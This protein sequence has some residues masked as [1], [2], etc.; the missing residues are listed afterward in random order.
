MSVATTSHSDVADLS[1]AYRRRDNEL[2]T[3]N[4][5]SRDLSATR[6]DESEIL[7]LVYRYAS[8][9]AETSTFAISLIDERTREVDLALWFRD[10]VRQLPRHYE[11]MGGL[12]GWVVEQRRPLLAVDIL[13]DPLPVKGMLLTAKQT[14]SALFV[15]LLT[16]DKTLGVM[17]VQAHQ[18]DTYTRE[19]E[20]LFFGLT[21]QAAVEIEQAR[22]YRA[23]LRR[24][25]QL[26]TIAEVESAGPAQ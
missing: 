13:K 1:L 12:A 23:Q 19:H 16:K 21:T 2:Q 3:L 15:P 8:K 9:V 20:R 22:L 14:R 18:P 11:T 25:R 6:L 26:E 4:D 7:E 5:F 10:G 17:S 24:T